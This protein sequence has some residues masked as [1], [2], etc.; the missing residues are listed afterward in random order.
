LF[1]AEGH[2][3]ACFGM[4]RHRDCYIDCY[5]DEWRNGVGRANSARILGWSHARQKSGGLRPR[6]SSKSR[7]SSSPDAIRVRI[8]G[9][10]ANRRTVNRQSVLDTVATT[11]HAWLM[12]DRSRIGPRDPDSW[13]DPTVQGRVTAPKPKPERDPAA[14]ALGRKGGLKGGRARAD[15]LT[16]EQRSEMARH[17]AAVRWGKT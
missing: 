11:G 12:P 15:I 10:A 7:W 4:I 17:A 3:T 14:V 9:S 2:R 6:R 16:A 1:E 5:I 8:R 13:T